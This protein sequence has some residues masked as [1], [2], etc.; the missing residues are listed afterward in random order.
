MKSKHHKLPEHALG[1]QRQFTRFH[2]G[3]PGQGEKIYLQAGL[4]ADELPGMLVLR[5]SA[6]N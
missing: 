6:A 2:F 3:Q 1:G 5:I 4:H